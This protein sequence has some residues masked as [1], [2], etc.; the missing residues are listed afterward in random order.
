MHVCGITHE[1]PSGHGRAPRARPCSPMQPI[2][3]T[4]FI[5]AIMTDWSVRPRSH[6]TWLYR[7]GC[8]LLEPVAHGW[9]HPS[10]EN[11]V[12]TP[13]PLH[14]DTAA[15]GSRPLRQCVCSYEQS[16]S[17]AVRVHAIA[18][19]RVAAAVAP[20]AR[21]RRP[22]D[23]ATDVDVPVRYGPGL[24]LERVLNSD[25]NSDRNL[26]RGSTCARCR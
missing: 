11:G 20:S 23:V 9:V 16:Q 24:A 15:G 22:L 6:S 5:H 2:E 3:N 1:S 14:F 19:P 26:K 4:W 12:A 17:S 18:E 13:F 21:S 25:Y 10:S 7:P 8:G